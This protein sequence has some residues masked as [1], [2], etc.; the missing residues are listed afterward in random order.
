M[1]FYNGVEEQTLVYQI[2]AKSRAASV[3]PFYGVKPVVF[4][5]DALVKTAKVPGI[6]DIKKTSK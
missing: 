5:S 3:I 6:K 1:Y 2:P 4:R